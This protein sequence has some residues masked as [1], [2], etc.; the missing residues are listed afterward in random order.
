[1]LCRPFWVCGV[2]HRGAGHGG[3]AARQGG[4][5]RP[6]CECGQA[7]GVCRAPRGCCSCAQARPDADVQRGCS[8]G[9]NAWRG[10]A[11]VR[12]HAQHAR[13]PN[14][15]PPWQHIHVPPA[16]A[17]PAHCPYWALP[18]ADAEQPAD[19]CHN[20]GRS[21]ETGGEAWCCS[22]N[23]LLCQCVLPMPAVRLPQMQPVLVTA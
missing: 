10:S 20:M 15:T 6:P 19:G 7:Q 1:M 9:A 11:W 5:L 3:H 2:S 18:A 17:P 14:C 16:R 8:C 23:K 12:A 21:G 4:P 13:R 22:E